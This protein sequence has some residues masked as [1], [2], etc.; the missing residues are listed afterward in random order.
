MIS[1]F[2]KLDLLILYHKYNIFTIAEKPCF[3][4]SK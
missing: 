1:I 2:Y 3:E 4:Y